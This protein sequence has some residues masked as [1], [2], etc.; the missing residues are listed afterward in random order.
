ME[1]SVATPRRSLWAPGLIAII[2]GAVLL[3]VAG[4]VLAAVLSHTRQTV[5]YPP[6]SPAGTVQRYLTLLQNGKTDQAYRLTRISDYGPVGTMTR[7]EF[8]QQFA[9]WSQTSHQVTLDS[10]SVSRQDATVTVQISSFS[11]GPFGASSESNRAVFTLVKDIG[12]W[13]ITGPPYLPG[14]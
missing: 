2:A 8:A 11:G 3:I 7:A 9:S 14:M 6:N 5:T 13:L 12:R 1:A 10:T 4:I